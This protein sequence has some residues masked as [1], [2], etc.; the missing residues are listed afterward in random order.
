MQQVVEHKAEAACGRHQG[1]L[2][3]KRCGFSCEYEGGR[4][5][6]DV[7]T[8]QDPAE[9]R[10]RERAAVTVAELARSVNGF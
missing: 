10:R 7:R 4:A 8:G 3:V 6:V 2:T 9:E 5:A 1:P